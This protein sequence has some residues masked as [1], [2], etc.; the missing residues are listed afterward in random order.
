MDA[1]ITK[2]IEKAKRLKTVEEE[3]G[4]G[5]KIDPQYEINALRAINTDLELR[6]MRKEEEIKKCKEDYINDLIETIDLIWREYKH[7]KSPYTLSLIYS[8]MVRVIEKNG[9]KTFGNE[10]EKYN[11][12][13]HDLV[14]YTSDDYDYITKSGQISNVLSP[15]IMIGDK[16][17]RPAKVLVKTES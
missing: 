6:L 7:A 3:F 8:S 1:K 9:G 11:S 17:I 12:E 16:V 4:I 13:I 10:G 14:G 15:G 5:R 2:N